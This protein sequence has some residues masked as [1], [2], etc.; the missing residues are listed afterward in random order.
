MNC[1]KKSVAAVAL[2][3]AGCAAPMQQSNAAH[4]RKV[5]TPTTDPQ[6]ELGPSR[7]QPVA[8]MAPPSTPTESPSLKKPAVEGPM[9]GYPQAKTEKPRTKVPDWPSSPHAPASPT[10]T[11][12]GSVPDPF[13]N[14]SRSSLLDEPRWERL[15]RSTDRR[16]IE[17]VQLGTG[18]VRVAIMASLHGDES[19]SVALIDQ[20]ARFVTGQAHEFRDVTVLIIRTPNPDG[21]AAKTPYNARSVDLNRNFPASNWKLNPAKHTGVK[22]GSEVETRAIV[23]LI[24][25]FRPVRLI[26]IKDSPAD[27]FVNHDGGLRDLAQDVAR[28]ASLKV[29]KDLGQATTGSVESYSWTQLNVPS[30]TLLLP[31]EST[32]QKAW[33][34][35]R[36]ALVAT[37]LGKSDPFEA[38]PGAGRSR[39][40]IPSN[41]S[42][43]SSWTPRRYA[44]PSR[45]LAETTS[46]AFPVPVPER[47]YLELPP[48][49]SRKGR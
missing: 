36:S 32:E 49:P 39:Q 11:R 29:V 7:G 43:E 35:N 18:R 20:L 47:G 40:P 28:V 45:S 9:L 22:A 38:A 34:K 41:T 37:I 44:P 3:L 25:E 48:P 1:W 4:T 46:P 24:S 17:T 8:P 23:R 14:V 5:P 12:S 33:E 21:M 15:H 19:Q 31:R 2:V 6:P 27:G 26:H 42:R 13:T 16:P 30:L 10:D